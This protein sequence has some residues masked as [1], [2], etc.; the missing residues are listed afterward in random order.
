MSDFTLSSRHFGVQTF[1]KHITVSYYR[2]LL[3]THLT[4]MMAVSMNIFSILIHKLYN[5]TCRTK[6]LSRSTI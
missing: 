4:P 3:C 2:V 5:K 6:R 1:Q